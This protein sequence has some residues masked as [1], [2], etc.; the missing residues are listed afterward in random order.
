M[1]D[2]TVSGKVERFDQTL[3]TDLAYR[4]AFDS[5]DDRSAALPDFL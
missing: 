1:P 4:Q 3:Q 5:D 2:P